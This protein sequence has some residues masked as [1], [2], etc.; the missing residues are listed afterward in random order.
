MDDIE[1]NINVRPDIMVEDLCVKV[2]LMDGVRGEHIACIIQ[3][4]LLAI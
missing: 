4:L 3:H 1:V 2:E